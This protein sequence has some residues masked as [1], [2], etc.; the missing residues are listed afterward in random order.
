MKADV[1]ALCFDL[2]QRKSVPLPDDIREGV[3]KF[4]VSGEEPASQAAL[5]EVSQGFVASG[6]SPVQPW[7][8]DR[9]GHLNVQFYLSRFAEGEKQ[10]LAALG[11]GPTRRRA[12]A[13]AIRPLHQRK[14]GRASG[15]ERVCQYV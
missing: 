15:R 3:G 6:R 13:V 5:P 8:C 7:E 9:M 12:D 4:K 10:L 1:L 11:Y 14:I 2:D